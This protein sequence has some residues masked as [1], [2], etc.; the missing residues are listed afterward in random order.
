MTTS[1]SNSERPDAKATIPNTHRRDV[2]VERY[3]EQVIINGPRD[4]TVELKAPDEATQTAGAIQAVIP[5][6][7]K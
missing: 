6:A 2:T 7:W 1:D 4:G 3:G 5:K